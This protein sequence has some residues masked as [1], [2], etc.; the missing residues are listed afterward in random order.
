MCG[1]GTPRPQLS[2]GTGDRAAVP[3][4]QRTRNVQSIHGRLA[5][6]TFL[7]CPGSPG[8]TS[9]AAET[10][11]GSTYFRRDEV[12]GSPGGHEP[13]AGVRA[14]LLFSW[15]RSSPRP[16]ARAPLGRRCLC[17]ERCCLQTQPGTGWPTTPRPGPQPPA[18]RALPPGPPPPAPAGAAAA[19]LAP[20]LFRPKVLAEGE[21]VRAA[22][23]RRRRLRT[24][25]V[26][27]VFLK[28]TLPAAAA[29]APAAESLGLQPGG[30]Q[31][32]YP[33][34]ALSSLS[35]C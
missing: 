15:G 22:G 21:S 23:R 3:G 17:A 8:P 30:S 6:R 9:P 5:P 4:H 32:A 31:V 7:P 12:W 28:S 1:A 27:S 19:T 33:V 26:P 14:P 35:D 13:P 34:S 24:R 25:G 16:G 10:R 2:R 29:A 11:Q 20:D 18:R